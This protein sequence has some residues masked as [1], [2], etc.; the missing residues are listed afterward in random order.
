MGYFNAVLFAGMGAG[1]LIGG[2]ITDAFSI[3]AAFL[4]MAVLNILGLIATLVFLKEMP[5]KTATHGHTSTM[6]PLKSRTMRGV[7]WYRMTTGIGTASLMAFMPLFA[8]LRIGLSASLI[9]IL[10][11]ARSPLSI[12]QSYTGRLADK[13]DRRSMVIWGGIGSAVAVA[14][15]PATGGFWSL[16]IVYI[17]VTIGQA[18]GI[19]AA[20]AYV[21]HEGRTYGMGASMT[22]FMMAMQTGN[23]IGPVVLGSIADGFGLESAFYA[24][25]IC[26]AAGVALFARMVRGSSR[27]PVSK[28]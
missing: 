28:C 17:S 20:N 11:A 22:M 13:W 1:P 25:A 16:L 12:L 8:G 5:R 24:A 3:R 10:L 15:L 9:G 7:L 23:G 27:E 19:P 6:A 21:V 2:V 4:C 26:M 14:L 18:F